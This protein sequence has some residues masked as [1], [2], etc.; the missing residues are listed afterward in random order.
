MKDLFDPEK[1]QIVFMMSFM[2]STGMIVGIVLLTNLFTPVKEKGYPAQ[3][4]QQNYRSEQDKRA[5]IMMI[6]ARL[7]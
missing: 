1:S 2:A 4:Q 7:L 6:A 3:G 5:T